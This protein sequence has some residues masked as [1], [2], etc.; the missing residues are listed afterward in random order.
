[1][2]CYSFKNESGEDVGEIKLG[3]ILWSVKFSDLDF[4]DD[5]VIFVQMLVIL[6]GALQALNEEL[7][8]LGLRVSW[9]KTTIQ[10]FDDILSVTV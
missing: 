7:E 5:S 2:P 4:T 9:V 10:A 1:M 6:M 3:C 8:P